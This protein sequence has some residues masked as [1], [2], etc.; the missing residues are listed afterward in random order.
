MNVFLKL[1]IFKKLRITVVSEICLNELF[2]I[3]EG[4]K[5]IRIMCF[6]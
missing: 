2:L 6:I 3:L 1:N 4:Y 5:K